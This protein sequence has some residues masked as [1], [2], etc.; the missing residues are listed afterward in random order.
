[1]ADGVDPSAKRRAER[2]AA[3]NTL[4]AVADEWLL[5]K[6]KSLTPATGQRDHDQI[7][8]WLIPYLGNRPISAIEAPEL[9][10]IYV[11]MMRLSRG[12]LCL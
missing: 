12:H 6:K 11:S 8:K 3:T 5:T 10:P 9:P 4:E 2:D 7:H 1:M